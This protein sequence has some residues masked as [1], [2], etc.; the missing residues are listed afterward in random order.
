MLLDDEENLVE[1][2]VSLSSLLEDDRIDLNPPTL[3]SAPLIKWKTE[4]KEKYK[5]CGC[6]FIGLFGAGHVFLNALFA[7]E[8]KNVIFEVIPSN[9][10]NPSLAASGPLINRPLGT[11]FSSPEYP[12]Y[13]FLALG[14]PVGENESNTFVQEIFKNLSPKRIIVAD[15]LESVA[16]L[17]STTLASVPMEPTLFYLS[18]SA[19][20]KNNY[21]VLSSFNVFKSPPVI[22]GLA[23]SFIAY[24]E[25]RALPCLYF[26]TVLTDSLLSSVSLCALLPSLLSE[27]ALALPAAPLAAGIPAAQLY[28]PSPQQALLFKAAVRASKFGKG[29]VL[30][31]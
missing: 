2:R 8:I 4:D 16:F 18:T 23:A 10:T 19:V 14:F 31:S 24:C 3:P 7:E 25:A 29:N 17:S 1:P 27:L 11:A 15:G 26:V 22:A 13:L 5:D 9:Q 20:A 28:E 6:L 12:N 30:Y 21:P